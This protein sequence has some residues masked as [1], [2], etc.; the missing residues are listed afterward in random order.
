MKWHSKEYKN[1]AGQWYI[2]RKRFLILP[3]KIEGQWRWLEKAEWTCRKV[4]TKW[5]K[6]KWIN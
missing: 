3:K 1:D 2:D 6:D 5:V 4:G